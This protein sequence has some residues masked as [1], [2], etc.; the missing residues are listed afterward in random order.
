M[1]LDVR[2]LEDKDIEKIHAL[3]NQCFS[4][5]WSIDGIRESL[6]QDYTVLLGAWLGEELAGYLIAYFSIDDCEIARIAVDEACRRRGVALRL[7]EE[8]EGICREKQAG[9]LLL[10][11]RRSNAAAVSLYKRFGFTEDGVRKNFYT[12]PMEDAILMSL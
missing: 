8:L 12:R 5:A 7:L 9:K 1:I 2:K 6:E 11:V 10:D 3:E 4:D